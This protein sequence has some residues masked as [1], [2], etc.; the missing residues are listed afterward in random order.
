MFF[1]LFSPKPPLA[2]QEKA[3]T[4][5]RMRWLA[6]QFGTDR[7][8]KDQIVLPDDQWFPERY[9][10]TPDDARQLLNRL[11]SLMQIAPSSIQIE[12]CEDSAMPGVA[13]L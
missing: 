1:G 7:L 11:C 10:G 3:S 5:V 13:R 2:V 12:V 8:L 9:E 4:E 6:R